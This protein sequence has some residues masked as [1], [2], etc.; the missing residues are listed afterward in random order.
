MSLR[1]DLVCGL[2]ARGVWKCRET[3]MVFPQRLC[4]QPPCVFSNVGKKSEPILSFTQ[5]QTLN[6][7]ISFTMPTALSSDCAPERR[8]QREES[9]AFPPY[10]IH[11]HKRGASGISDEEN[12][13]LG[14]CVVVVE[15][16][17]N[18]SPEG[19]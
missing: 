6:I 10:M 17:A 14:C 4:Q 5:H 9:T 3:W 19:K 16:H 15:T 18:S 8:Q 11:T 7:E 13:G 2:S 12:L 1:E